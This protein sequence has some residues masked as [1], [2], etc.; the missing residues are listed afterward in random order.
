MAKKALSIN[1][2]IERVILSDILPYEVPILFSN[3]YCYRFFCEH[4]IKFNDNK[5][6]WTYRDDVL[7]NLICMLVGADASELRYVNK[8]KIKFSTLDLDKK[9]VPSIPFIFSTSHKQDQLRQLALMHPKAQLMVVDFYNEFKDLLVYYCGR[10]EFS[11]R[12]PTRVAGCTYIDSRAQIELVDKEAALVEMEG[13]NYENL[14]SFFVYEKFSNVFKFYE[15]REHLQCEREF[16]Y[17]A[18]YDISS[19]FDSI[20]THSIAWAIYGKEYSKRNLSDLKGTFP[21]RFDSLMQRLNHNETNGILI[22]P[23]VSRIFAEII[24]QAVDID[25]CSKLLSKGIVHGEDYRIYR[26]VDDFFVF[27]NSEEICRQVKMV[28][29][30]SLKI[31][32]LSL[33]KGKEETLA[34]PIITPISIAKKRVSDLFDRTLRYEISLVVVDGEDLPRGEIYIG[35]S[36]LIT[37]FKSILATSGVGYGDILNYSLSVVERKVRVLIDTY[38][39][40]QKREG[41]DRSLSRSLEAILGFVFFI[42][43]VSPKVNTTIKLCRICQRVLSFYQREPIGLDYGALISQVIYERCRGIMDSN[44]DGK[45]AKIEVMYLLVLM[46]QLGN[47]YRIDEATLSS[48][49]GFEMVSGNYRA[50]SSLNY[51]SIITLLFYIEEKKRYSQLRSALEVH[52][53]EKFELKKDSL[54]GDSEMIHLAL[55]LVSCP[56]ICKKV[57]VAILK[58]Y[59]VPENN[60]LRIQKYNEHWFTKWG[61][62]DLSKELD[63]KVS[64]EVY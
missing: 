5:I 15:S 36:S 33:N 41:R 51:F 59:N 38:G 30:E 60:L 24:L 31:Y 23:E 10:S 22:G 6:S 19:C 26:Y 9:E 7:D 61:E 17:L 20:Y 8:G 1:F 11:L 48:C 37:E 54:A 57:K 2:P 34:R 12:S 27:Y 40:I 50:K 16:Q 45:S 58:L 28:L 39:K 55:D 47:G 29:Q 42:Y 62:F 53:L 21:G 52:I 25:V 43:A 49:F 63:A 35:K 56:H 14:R 44:S 18:K 46:R 64:Q 32:K 4:T 3:R 13:E